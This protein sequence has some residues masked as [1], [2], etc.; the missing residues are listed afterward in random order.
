MR[1][2]CSGDGHCLIQTSHSAP[3]Y[4]GTKYDDML[5]KYDCKPI[6]CNNF[7]ICG[8]TAPKY[9]LRLTTGKN[10][11]I[12]CDQ[13]YG[14]LNIVN[15]NIPECEICNET[16]VG[17]RQKCGHF[18]CAIC[19]KKIYEKEPQPQF[20]D[21]DEFPNSVFT[22][23]YLK[24]KKIHT[25]WE[26]NDEI[27][28]EP[29]FKGTKFIPDELEISQLFLDY[30]QK[31]N[32]WIESIQQTPSCPFCR[33]KNE[34][35][36][37]K[38]NNLNHFEY[39]SHRC[40]EFSP[41]LD[42][43][44]EES[45]HIYLGILKTGI[46][47]NKKFLHTVL[48][49]CKIQDNRKLIV[50]NDEKEVGF[51]DPKIKDKKLIINKYSIGIDINMQI[52]ANYHDDIYWTDEELSDI[53]LSFSTEINNIVDEPLI[54][55]KISEY[56]YDKDDCDCDYCD[57]NRDI[58]NTN[59]TTFDPEYYKQFRQEIQDRLMKKPKK[60]ITLKLK[61]ADGGYKIIRPKNK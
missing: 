51:G 13:K 31:R 41:N 7:I 53:I 2:Q 37:T 22:P 35:E 40:I 6:K 8:D 23:E 33:S 18:V 46:H 36:K 25:K 61:Q 47:R 16:R 44:D 59:N 32:E 15:T 1:R 10:V 34:S 17:I 9:L 60:K 50:I 48:R 57:N 4:N 28:E 30:I 27:T 19:F 43:A 54:Q 58:D 49:K 52:H 56:I 20:P 29:E 12:N 21:D 42:D 24:F 11:C 3:K 26:A 45:I 14:K 38:Q 55:G 5:C 39:D